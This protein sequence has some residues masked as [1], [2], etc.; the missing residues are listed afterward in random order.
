MSDAPSLLPNNAT[1]L[2]RSL[3]LFPVRIAPDPKRIA[4]LWDAETC[5]AHLLPYLAWAFS[6]DDWQD[7]WPETQ[8]RKVLLDAIAVHRRK[9]TVRAVKDALASAGFGDAQVIERHGWEK[10]N[11]AMTYNGTPTYSTPDHWAEYR[12]RLNR[13]I[14]IE[15]AAQVRA[16]LEKVAPARSRLKALEFTE[17]LNTYNA[18]V[19]HDG[20]YTHGVA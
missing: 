16:I 8:R 19:S 14:T 6:V 5:P 20:Q 11:G 7:D 18:R 3:D 12:V 10:H 1:P 13:P 17:A 2:E 15:Q 9:G 4:T